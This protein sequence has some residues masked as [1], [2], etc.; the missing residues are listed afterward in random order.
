[1]NELYTLPQDNQLVGEEKFL[2][3]KVSSNK[4]RKDYQIT[5]LF[6]HLQQNNI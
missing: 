4:W 5:I 6:F 3:R 1:M 2:S